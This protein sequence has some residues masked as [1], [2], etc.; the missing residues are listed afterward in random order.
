MTL[1]LLGRS[2]DTF[3]VGSPRLTG[4]KL[5]KAVAIGALLALLAVPAGLAGPNLKIGAVEDGAIWSSSPAAAMNL[6]RSAGFDTIRMT[7][8]WSTGMTQLPPA[9]MGRIQ[10]AAMAA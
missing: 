2:A 8:Q 9:Q 1:M 4:S 3:A 5:V 6:A 7:A 10:Q